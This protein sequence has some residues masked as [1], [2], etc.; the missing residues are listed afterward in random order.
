MSLGNTGI[1]GDERVIEYSLV[2]LDLS[3]S[4][5]LAVAEEY[6]FSIFVCA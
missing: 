3:A 2:G 5:V 4:Q 6:S 1:A